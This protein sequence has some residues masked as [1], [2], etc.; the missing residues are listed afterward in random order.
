MLAHG[1]ARH[2][3]RGETSILDFES[4]RWRQHPR[5]TSSQSL[6]IGDVGN[7]RHELHRRV[8]AKLH[9]RADLVP[10]LHAPIVEPLRRLLIV[11]ASPRARHVRRAALGPLAGEPERHRALQVIGPSPLNTLTEADGPTRKL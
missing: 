4:Q 7:G 3:E 11:Q 5:H 8:S 2:L 10:L 1:W 6:W 9:H